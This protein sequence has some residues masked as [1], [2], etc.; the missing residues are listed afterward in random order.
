LLGG[1]CVA[2]LFGNM[3]RGMLVTLEN[4]ENGDRH[5]SKNSACPH[6]PHFRCGNAVT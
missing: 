5:Y 4:G 6:F 1:L 2:L 3:P